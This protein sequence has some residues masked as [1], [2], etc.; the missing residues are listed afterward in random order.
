[1]YE[2]SM[3]TI[4][5]EGANIDGNTFDALGKIDV[6]NTVQFAVRL[7]LPSLRCC[8]DT[9]FAEGCRRESLWH[10]PHAQSSTIPRV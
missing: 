1:M 10:W 8:C 6:D 9:S 5:A 3:K 4:Q 7:P 2:A